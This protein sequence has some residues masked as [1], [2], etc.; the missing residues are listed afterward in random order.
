M[1]V[2]VNLVNKFE[3]ELN[4]ASLALDEK[5]DIKLPIN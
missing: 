4:L 1:K 3:Y 5:S 2:K